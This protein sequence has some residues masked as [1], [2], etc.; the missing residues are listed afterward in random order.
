ME[1]SAYR[2]INRQVARFFDERAEGWDDCVS[3]QHTKRLA[4]IVAELDIPR[5]ACIVDVGSGTGVLIPFLRDKIGPAGRIIAMDLSPAMIRAAKNR[6]CACRPL[7]LVADALDLPLCAACADCICCNSVFPHFHDQARAV[8]ELARALRFGGRLVVCHTQSRA[9]IN[10]FHRKVGGVVGGDEI[11][12]DAAMRR[13]IRAA[14]LRIIRLED[15]E[16]RYLMIAE[17]P[18]SEATEQ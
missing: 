18:L 8:A 6:R 7:P 12:D 2:R 17:K 13:I 5:G 4:G 11:P 16:D 3:P 1:T 10:A 15:R 14:G 9:A